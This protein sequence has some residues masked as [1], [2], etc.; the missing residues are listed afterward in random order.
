M[1]KEKLLDNSLKA[2]SNEQRIIEFD[3][4]ILLF[5]DIIK[6]ENLEHLNISIYIDTLGTKVKEFNAYAKLEKKD[7]YEVVFCPKLLTLIEGL[8]IEL[9]EKYKESFAVIDK[10][11]FYD[12]ENR[13]KLQKYI[14]HYYIIHIFYHELFHIL[15]GHLKYLND[16]KS[17]NQILEFEET[18][19]KNIE[20]LYLEIDADKFASIASVF[21]WLKYIE[22]INKLGF[23]FKESLYIIF[24]S[25]NELFYI[26]HLLNR[27]AE[28][29]KGHPI[30]FDR[31]LLFNHHFMSALE[32]NDLENALEI[33]DLNLEDIN[34]LNYL[35]MA[36]FTKKYKIENLFEGCDTLN[37]KKEYD[38]FL[39]DTKLN[40]YLYD[41]NKGTVPK[42]KLNQ[43]RK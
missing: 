8:S 9:T 13:N 36:E 17:L 14:Y 23:N 7:S 30:L 6:K 43:E 37:I 35:T 19:K 28:I 22:N 24:M 34:K 12:K 41:I 26:F 25:M 21:E 18:N 16:S 3:N 40:L 42:I 39:I 38:N 32:N 31:V 27:K 4:I 20:N 5:E 15:R 33:L 1:I 29:R 10:K 11:M 2:K